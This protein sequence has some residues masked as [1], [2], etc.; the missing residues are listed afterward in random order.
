L[1]TLRA[2][3]ETL[4]ATRPGK[5]MGRDALV[6]RVNQRYVGRHGALK[7]ATALNRKRIHATAKIMPS[8]PIAET[9]AALQRDRLIVDIVP[10]CDL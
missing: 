1:L 10:V 3:V 7:L 4:K 2:I 6:A 5:P 8:E 9:S